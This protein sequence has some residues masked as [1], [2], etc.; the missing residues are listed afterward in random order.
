MT[1]SRNNSVRSRTRTEI[2]RLEVLV[3]IIVLK[4]EED[5]KG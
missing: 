1:E 4:N 2:N 3:R 5:V